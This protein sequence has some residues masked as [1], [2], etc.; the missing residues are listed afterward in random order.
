MS[1]K[2]EDKA[3]DMLDQ[4]MQFAGE[5]S[6]KLSELASTYGEDVIDATL[7]VVQINGVQTLLLAFVYLV[8]SLISFWFIIRKMYPWCIDNNTRRYFD[9]T[10]WIAFIICSGST[11]AFFGNS[12][13]II[14]NVWNWIAIFEPKLWIAYKILNAAI[15]KTL[16]N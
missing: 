4:T 16:G 12:L 14:F 10:Q 3:V 8:A 13:S 5:V 15:T 6:H 1:G 2:L 11:V 9:G 7:K